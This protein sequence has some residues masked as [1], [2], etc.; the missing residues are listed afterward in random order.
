[1]GF[2]MKYIP[3]LMTLSSLATSIIACQTYPVVLDQLFPQSASTCVLDTGMQVCSDLVQLDG[4]TDTLC[5]CWM[6]AL[7]GK[8]VRLQAGIERL[9]AHNQESKLHADD[10]VYLLAMINRV[11]I[12]YESVRCDAEYQVLYHTA[13]HTIKGSIA[14][15]LV[16]VYARS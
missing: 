7:L 8:M 6:D 11:E 14:R 16:Q 1:M 12:A 10:L 4:A 2:V 13:L 15:L 5:A 3:V 9:M